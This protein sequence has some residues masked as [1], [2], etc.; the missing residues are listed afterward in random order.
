MTRPPT[1]AC[2]ALLLLMACSEPETAEDPTSAGEEAEVPAAPQP[3]GPDEDAPVDEGEPPMLTGR[4]A[5]WHAI[6]PPARDSPLWRCAGF[7]DHSYRVVRDHRSVAVED[8]PPNGHTVDPIPD[9]LRPPAGLRGSVHVHRVEG[10]AL[11]GADAGEWGGGLWL[12]TRGADARALSESEMRGIRGFVETPHGV[13][14]LAGMTHLSL[15]EGELLRIG[16]AP[17]FE[18]STFAE[19]PAGPSA[20]TAHGDEVLV[21]SHQGLIRVSAEGETT[22]IH[23]TRWL[24]PTSILSA[25]GFVFVG[26]R[27][28]VVQLAPEGDGWAERRWFVPEVCDSPRFDEA[29]LEC[30]CGD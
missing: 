5:S 13:L 11:I 4:L 14:A 6:E 16:P 15:D 25:F 30:H 3:E 7:S 26:M 17:D 9:G 23:E 8:A 10:G 22:L 2:A 24:Y 28:A 19:L 20:A 18:V 21:A 1:T 29:S 12:A 27:Y